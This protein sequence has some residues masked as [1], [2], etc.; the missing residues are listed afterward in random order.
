MIPVED[1]GTEEAVF[2]HIKKLAYDFNELYQNDY[3]GFFCIA[4]IQ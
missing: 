1:E 2:N 4:L 3:V